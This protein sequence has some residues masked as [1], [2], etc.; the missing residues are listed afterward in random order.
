MSADSVDKLAPCMPFGDGIIISK[1]GG[2]AADGLN[3]LTLVITNILKFN[4][5]YL[6]GLIANNLT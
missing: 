1:V 6:L 4:N 3:N 5:T 2:A